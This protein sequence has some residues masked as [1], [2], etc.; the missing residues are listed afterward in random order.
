MKRFAFSKTNQATIL[1]MV[2]AMPVVADPIWIT[3]AEAGVTD[4]YIAWM[5]IAAAGATMIYGLYG[6]AVAQ[7]PLV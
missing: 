4:Q 6:R 5:K 1:A 7:G 2:Q 3:V